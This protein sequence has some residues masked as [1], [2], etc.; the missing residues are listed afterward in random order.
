M[1]LHVDYACIGAD[2]RENNDA[3]DKDLGKEASCCKEKG[4][5]KEGRSEKARGQKKPREKGL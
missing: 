4:F 1:S 3:N 2:L 5:E